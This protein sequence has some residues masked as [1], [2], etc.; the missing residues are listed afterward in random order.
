MYFAAADRTLRCLRF[1]SGRPKWRVR[2]GAIS[3]A[4]PIALK[5]FLY[6]LCYDDDIYVLNARNG[7]QLTRVRLGHRLDSEPLNTGS[8]LMVVPFTEAAV[9]GLALPRL[10]TVGRYALKVPGEWFTTAPLRVADRIA[11]G[12]GRNEGRI[13]A[14]TVAQKKKDAEEPGGPTTPSSRP[15]PTASWNT[16]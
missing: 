7:H 1:R 8:H 12:Y 13:L 4:R 2:L 16:A 9:V 14:L 3:T 15:R 6:V 5:P 10:Q 11:V